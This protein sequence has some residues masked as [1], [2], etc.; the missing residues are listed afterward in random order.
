M[1]NPQQL[2]REQSVEHH[3][4][5]LPISTPIKERDTK[6]V[7]EGINYHS[8]KYVDGIM[9]ITKE[10]RI[11]QSGVY[12]LNSFVSENVQELDRY[13]DEYKNVLLEEG[14]VDFTSPVDLQIQNVA[15]V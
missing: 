6:E 10:E 7:L 2:L 13:I 14:V 9:G 3:N 5:Q 15:F 12:Y 8:F 11:I 4:P 1:D